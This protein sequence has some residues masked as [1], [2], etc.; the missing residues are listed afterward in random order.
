MTQTEK[1]RSPRPFAIAAILFFIPALISF[2]LRQRGLWAEYPGIFFHL[3]IFFLVSM[4]EAPSWG[5]AAGYLWIGLDVLTGA[6]MINH[7][8]FEIA[9]NVRLGGHIFAGLWLMATS[10]RATKGMKITGM[11]AGIWLSGYTFLAPL[12]PAV[13]L[14]P[15]SILMVIWLVIVAKQNRTVPAE[16]LR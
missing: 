14:S 6:L 11:I 16:S 2:A 13:F 8:P 4:L 1:I 10:W 15:A 9:F 12:L 3:S 5:K 7:V